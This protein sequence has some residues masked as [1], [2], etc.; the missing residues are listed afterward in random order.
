MIGQEIAD[1]VSMAN[2]KP[3]KLKLE[4]VAFEYNILLRNSTELMAL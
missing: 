4:K 3:I 2:P 1:A